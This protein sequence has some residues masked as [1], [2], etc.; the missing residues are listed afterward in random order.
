M[1]IRVERTP[2]PGIGARYDLMTSSG[3]RVGLVLHRDG[4]RELIISSREDPDSCIATIPLGQDEAQAL[5]EILSSEYEH[6]A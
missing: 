1:S 3:R 4:R 5:A 2:L 6:P